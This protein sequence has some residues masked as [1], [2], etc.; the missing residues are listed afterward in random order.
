MRYLA[1]TFLFFCQSLFAADGESCD[2]S[3]DFDKNFFHLIE[4]CEKHNIPQEECDAHIDSA[5]T[6]SEAAFKSRLYNLKNKPVSTKLHDISPSISKQ[7]W[8]EIPTKHS[9]AFKK[10]KDLSSIEMSGFTKQIE[11]GKQAKEYFTSLNAAEIKNLF[12]IIEKM[13][14]SST[15]VELDNFLMIK[16]RESLSRA[17][18]SR[19]NC[20]GDNVFSVRLSTQAR[21]CY[22]L[23]NAESTSIKILCIGIGRQCYEH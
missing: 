9:E 2:L 22:Q 16:K 10:L 23:V 14:T 15:K 21:M 17:D 4:W 7:D 6:L 19:K 20:K 18:S 3:G 12:E 11:F 8:S 1:L 13:K 5:N